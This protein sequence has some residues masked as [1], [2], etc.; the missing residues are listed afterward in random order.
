[1]P[2]GGGVEVIRQVARRAAGAALPRAVGLRRRRGRDR[3]DP[4]RRARLRDEVDLRRGAGRRD[5]AGSAT[6]TRSSRRG[7]R[8]SCSTPSTGEIPEAEVDP[9][10]DQLTLR[11]REVLRL[12]ARGY[13]YKEIALQ[14][15]HLAEDGRGARQR[16]AAKAPALEPPR[17]QPLGGRA[18]AGR[19][20]PGLAA[21]RQRPRAPRRRRR[22]AGNG[23]CSRR[24]RGSSRAGPR[25]ARRESP[26]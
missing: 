13:L 18:A 8:A 7:S 25:G 9:E 15:R 19:L 1:M 20:K 10:L 5:R 4:R 17:A 26:S 12:I 6:A 24:R 22:R 2:G 23:P 21:T 16:R 3:G 11:E 14:P